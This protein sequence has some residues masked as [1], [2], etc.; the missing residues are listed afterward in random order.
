[1]TLTTPTGFL[2]V[3]HR[4]LSNFELLISAQPGDNSQ[5]HVHMVAVGTDIQFTYIFPPDEA[6]ADS[7]EAILKRCS[8]YTMQAAQLE[9]EHLK[10]NNHAAH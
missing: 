3:I 2:P 7:I 5:V 4:Q 9:L 1:M 8:A 6:F 10:S